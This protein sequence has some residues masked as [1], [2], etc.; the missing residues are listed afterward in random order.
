MTALPTILLLVNPFAGNGN[1]LKCLDV[2]TTELSKKTI[3]FKIYKSDWPIGFGENDDIWII[4]GDGTLNFFINKYKNC[5]NAIAIFSGGSGNDFAWKLYGKI[6]IKEQIEI[7]LSASCKYVDA[8]K[9]N[10]KI[11]INGIG[12][13]FDGEVLKSMTIVRKIG[14]HL[15]YLL[16]VIKKIISFKEK[17]FS[18]TINER[19][20][21]GKFLLVSLFNSS[22][23]GGGFHIAPTAMVDDGKL[24][25]I[26]CKQ[27]PVLKRL[28]FLP[29]IEKGKHIGLP[30]IEHIKNARFYIECNETIA[31]QIDGE[32]MFGNKFKVE[33]LSKKFLFK[34]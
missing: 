23:T 30:F 13:G 1:A 19:K 28:K 25:L 15:G 22:R 4:G 34:F 8:A 6:S 24:D 31:A 32:L 12:I 5:K 20:I 21:V 17:E 10:D 33:T 29:I 14:G 18:I 9:C 7:V 3:H 27:L 11:F 16:V 2:I 26:L